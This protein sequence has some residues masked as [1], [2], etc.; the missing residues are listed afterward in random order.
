MRARCLGTGMQFE[1]K[2]NKSNYKQGYLSA[3]VLRG[4][5]TKSE[6]VINKSHR[7]IDTIRS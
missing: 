2:R 6:N 4:N 1:Q 3:R 7:Q 5:I